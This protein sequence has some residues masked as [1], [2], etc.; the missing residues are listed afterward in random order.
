[1]KA[2]KVSTVHSGRGVVLE[3]I[4]ESQARSNRLTIALWTLEEHE[5]RI[6][7]TTR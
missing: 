1:V 5:G 3:A 2:T 7:E 4:R 6:V